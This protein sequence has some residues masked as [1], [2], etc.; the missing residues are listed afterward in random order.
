MT[1]ESI[2]QESTIQYARKATRDTAKRLARFFS[3]RLVLQMLT[4]V[5]GVYITILVAN[6]GGYVD[7][8]LRASII[9]QANMEVSAMV[10]NTN[11][12]PDKRAEMVKD[13]IA[14]RET[15]AGLD[16]PFIR[17][18]FTHLWNALTLNFGRARFM[19]S[20]HGSR[21]VRNIIL[22]RLPA[23]LLLMGTSQLLLFA[24]TI[25]VAL[26]VSRHYGSAWDRIIVAMS[27][28]SS[29]PPWF[30]GIFLILIFAA[31]LKVLP[32]SG[33]VDAPPPP[34]KWQYFLNILKHLI[35]PAGSL[36]ISGFFISTYSW[37]T[38]FLIYSSE[39]YVDMAKAKGLSSRA[40][41]RRYI[42]R[43]TL[44]SIITSFALLLV[45][46][47]T[48][49]TLTETIFLWPG[50]GTT[51]FEAISKYDTAV[52]VGTTIIQ[53]Y[54]LGITVFFLD[55]LYA[56]VDPRVKLGGGR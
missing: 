52:I 13:L 16:K 33:M 7:T 41:E 30:Y 54:L 45:G 49:A 11:T 9:E 36:F 20:N 40:I 19:V 35:L 38:F 27:P 26:A 44:P 2:S 53:A 10:A 12:P 21:M 25:S 51:I 56:I 4:I 39:D 28:T 29:I 31:W 32:F 46:I 55:F 48:G 47:W 43:P 42:L 24:V 23:T 17:R 1:T 18:S 22:E 3:I 8:I 14:E 5:I 6:M 15:L 50:L 37:R 34:T